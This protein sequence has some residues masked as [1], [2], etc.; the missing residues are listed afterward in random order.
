[1]GLLESLNKVADKAVKVTSDKLSE[2]TKKIDKTISGADSGSVL[3]GILGNATSQN[4]SVVNEKWSHM[5]IENENV[6]SAYKLVRDE[7]VITNIR[8][9]FVDAQ[10][11]TG[12]K[13]A[14]TQIFLDSIVNVQYTAAGF[15]FDDT[16]MYITYISTPYYKAYNATLS[17][18]H[19]SF[20]KKLDVSDLY[21][22]LVQLC[23]E[24]RQKI[25]S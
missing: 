25:N 14:I 18:Y 11:V 9:L 12:Q 22:F 15:G 3:Q 2:T 5:F 13:K 19:F 7:I 4:I 1:M 23:T 21:R 24:N 20:P 17:S 16:D 10:G 6:I 8:L